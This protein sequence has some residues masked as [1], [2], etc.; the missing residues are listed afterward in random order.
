M[1]KLLSGLGVVLI[2]TLSSG[3]NE[4]TGPSPTP[5]PSTNSTAAPVVRSV[6]R[7]PYDEGGWLFHGRNFEPSPIATFES[8]TTVVRLF[9]VRSYPNG[10]LLD[11]RGSLTKPGTYAPCVRTSF[12]KGCGSGSSLIIVK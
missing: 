3:C 9:I 10:T 6:D 2:V 1:C 7:G 5:N 12:G 4:V 11:V 8:G